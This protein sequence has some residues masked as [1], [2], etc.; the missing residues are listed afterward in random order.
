MLELCGIRS[1]RSFPLLPG[2]GV[3]VLDRVLPIGQIEWF[4]I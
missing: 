3:V 1:T 2:P 4:E